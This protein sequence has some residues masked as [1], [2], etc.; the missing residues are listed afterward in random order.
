MSETAFMNAYRDAFIHTFERQQSVLRQ[1]CTTEC[2]V[3]GDKAYFLVAGSGGATAVTRGANGLIPARADSN[4]QLY[5][6]LAEWHD[7]V[8]KTGFTVSAS[9]GNQIAIMQ[10]TS[11]AVM[12][13]KIDDLILAALDDTTV[14]TGTSTTANLRLIG[15]AKAILGTNNAAGGSITGLITP[16]FHAYLMEIPAFSNAEYVSRKP[17]DEG[18]NPDGSMPMFSWYGID[19][20]EHSGLSGIGTSAEKCFLFN[21]SAIGHA[22]DTGN[23][24]STLGFDDQNKYHYVRTSMAMGAKLLQTNGVVQINH[25]GSAMVASA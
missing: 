6:Q 20:I 2:E 24:E 8:V 1:R 9:Q 18:G 23:L 4:T 25:D 13:R 21:Q 7:K 12:N 11:M 17:F 15:K 19:W 22:C 16:A 10:R 3:K 14:N 5:A